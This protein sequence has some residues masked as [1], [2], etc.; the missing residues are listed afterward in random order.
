VKSRIGVT[1]P[2]LAPFRSGSRSLFYHP[3]NHGEGSV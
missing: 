1:C 2:T 3:S